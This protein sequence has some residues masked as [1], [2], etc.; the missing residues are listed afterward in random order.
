MFTIEVE[1]MEKDEE[2][3]LESLNMYHG[4]C[5]GG[6]IRFSPF[7]KAEKDRFSCSRCSTERL[8]YLSEEQKIKIIRVAIEGGELKLGEDIIVVQRGEDE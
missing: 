2:F 1:K 7:G 6:I 4:E 5:L 3:D 8:L